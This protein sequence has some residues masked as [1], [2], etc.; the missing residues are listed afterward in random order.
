MIKI[1]T[2]LWENFK[3]Y[4]ILIVLLVTSLVTLS[5]NQKSEIKKVKAVAFGS[6]A[7][8]SSIVSDVI[9]I[10]KV[11]SENE[12]LRSVN[13]ELMLQVNRLREYG[14]V[15]TELKDMLSLKDTTSFPLIPAKIVSKALT[16]SQSTITINAGSNMGIKAG[17]P[18]VNDKG[19]VG[20]I[21]TT[22]EDFSIAKTL[23]NRD[24]K[25]TVKDERSRVDG[26]MKWNGEN[27]V[28]VNVPKTYDIEAGDRIVIS[29]LSS[30]LSLPLPVGVVAGLNHVETGIF[31]EVKINPYVDFVKTEYVFV[32]GI[33]SSKQKNN[34]EL[35]FYNK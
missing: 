1:I 30:V 6:F 24:L 18:V 5:L 12:R 26:V 29:D 34:L 17:M 13:A 20:I 23:R 31:N 4:I 19:L 7:A 32:L 9:D 8:V 35:N 33:V 10:S 15:N 3:E 16:I 22:S 28:M 14:I 25:L 27:L 21:S 11:K 2:E